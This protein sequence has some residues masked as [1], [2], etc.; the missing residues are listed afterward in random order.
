[1]NYGRLESAN[2]MFGFVFK[3]CRPDKSLVKKSTVDRIIQTE[4]YC[5]FM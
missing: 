3:Q 5:P 2:T 1:M 4:N